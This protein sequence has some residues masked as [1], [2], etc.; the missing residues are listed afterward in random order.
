MIWV[1]LLLTIGAIAL[2]TRSALGGRLSAYRGAVHEG[3]DLEGAL[4]RNLYRGETVAAE[5]L[6]D[7]ASRLRAFAAA[8]EQTSAERLIEGHLPA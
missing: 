1:V 8:L 5:A 2:V 3:G 4:A 7:V 6:G